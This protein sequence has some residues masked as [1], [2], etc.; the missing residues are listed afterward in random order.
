MRGI[1]LE[2]NRC[3]VGATTSIED[4]KN[5]PIMSTF[6]PKMPAYF[7]RIAATPIRHRATLGGNLVNASP[8]GDLTIF[9][10]ALGA[11]IILSQSEIG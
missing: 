8:I 6:F 4:L 5:S 2:Q 1:R 7:Q 10:L 3:Y 11:H 9:F